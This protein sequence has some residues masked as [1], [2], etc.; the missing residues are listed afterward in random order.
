MVRGDH[1]EKD[2]L[3]ARVRRCTLR[4]SLVAAALTILVGCSTAPMPPAFTQDEL[5]A[6]CERQGGWWH[7]DHLTGGICEYEQAG[8]M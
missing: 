2:Q 7:P 6:I 5:K 8:S 3:V 1:W 4:P